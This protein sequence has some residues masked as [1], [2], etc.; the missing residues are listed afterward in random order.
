MKKLVTSRSAAATRDLRLKVPD[1]IFQIAAGDRGAVDMPMGA[2]GGGKDA[3]FMRRAFQN[4]VNAHP[5][6]ILWAPCRAQVLTVSKLIFATVIL[7]PIILRQ[8][9]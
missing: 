5:L 2:G 9:I 3:S 1:R 8:I 6:S 4:K 7:Q